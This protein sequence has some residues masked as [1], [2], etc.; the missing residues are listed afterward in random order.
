MA[1]RYNGWVNYETWCW[2]LWMDNDQGTHEHWRDVAQEALDDTDPDDTLDERRE[3]AADQLAG[4][5]ESDCDEAAP[6]LAGPFADLMTS[7]LQVIDWREIA[8]H[9]LA[10]LEPAESDDDED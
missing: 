2:A 10:D 4:L 9:I 5:L 8:E 1:E 3:T 7:A 6:S